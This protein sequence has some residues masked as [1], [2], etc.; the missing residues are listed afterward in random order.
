[1]SNTEEKTFALSEPIFPLASPK[2]ALGQDYRTRFIAVAP[3]GGR[4]T[5]TDHPALPTTPQALAETARAC[6]DAGASMM[7]IHVRDKQERHLLD[8]EAYRSAIDAITSACGDRLVLQ[9]TTEALG[10]YTPDVQ[11][12]LVR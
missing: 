1:M 6:L 7:H 12:A 9:I 8:V 11:R 4:R 5:H 2:N 3:N 10:K